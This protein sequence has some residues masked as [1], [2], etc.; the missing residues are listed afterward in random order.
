LSPKEIYTNFFVATATTQVLSWPVNFFKFTLVLKTL[1]GF[2]QFDSVAN[3]EIVLVL[4]A[5]VFNKRI[6]TR[7]VYLRLLIGILTVFP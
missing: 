4:L 1:R 5:A 7:L 6:K 3:R 2:Q